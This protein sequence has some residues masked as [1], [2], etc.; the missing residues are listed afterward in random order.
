MENLKLLDNIAKAYAFLV[1]EDFKTYCKQYEY[2]D[3]QDPL[4]WAA[5][6]DCK[7]TYGKFISLGFTASD[8]EN[9]VTGEIESLKI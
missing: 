8:I 5:W 2:Y 3:M 9:L 6:K 1:C 7:T 4:A